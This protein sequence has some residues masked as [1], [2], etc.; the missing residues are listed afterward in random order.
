MGRTYAI[1]D[2]HGR[3]DLLCAALDFLEERPEGGTIVFLGDYVD[4][5]P[6]SRQIIRR[7]MV[8]P[9]KA[10][11]KW[12]CLKGN[13]EDMMVAALRGEAEFGWW[14]GNG[15]GQ[16]LESF[17]GDVPEECVEWADK[18]PLYHQDAHRIFVHADADE[19]KPMSEQTEARLLWTRRGKHQDCHHPEG[20]VVHGHTPFEDGPVVLD[21]RAN[22]DAGAVWTGN[23]AIAGFNNDVPGKPVELIRVEVK[24]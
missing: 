22:L 16:T 14:V 20:Y 9:T 13:H 2:L 1:P 15:G 7:L 24:P 17:D 6:Q 23:L 4:R 3:F 21:G 10:R 12:V 5:G 11:W 8:G 19:T 18:L